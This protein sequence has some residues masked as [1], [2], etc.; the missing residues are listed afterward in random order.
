MNINVWGRAGS[1]RAKG[2]KAA[3]VANLMLVLSFLQSGMER[4]QSFLYIRAG[5]RKPGTD[6]WDQI[7]RE[8]QKGRTKG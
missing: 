1:E 2:P 5:L 8:A 7:C 6:Q 4:R 3:T